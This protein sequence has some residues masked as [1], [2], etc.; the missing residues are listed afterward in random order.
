M[1]DFITKGVGIID[2]VKNKSGTPKPVVAVATVRQIDK[3]W[4]GQCLEFAFSNLSKEFALGRIKL[5]VKS[6]NGPTS[7]GGN[8]AAE[9]LT[10]EIN[11]ELPSTIFMLR[12]PIAF[13]VRA[14]AEQDNDALYISYC[15]TLDRPGLKGSLV[16]I[17]EFLSP[18]GEQIKH[19]KVVL[20][21]PQS[22]SMTLILSRPRNLVPHIVPVQST[23]SP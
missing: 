2:I 19:L 3:E 14:Q 8:Q 4:G 10:R 15:P 16:I 11:Q 6:S 9:I 17:P 18:S 5:K 7:T 20:P 23:N 13:D 21:D 22:K 1:F 12:K